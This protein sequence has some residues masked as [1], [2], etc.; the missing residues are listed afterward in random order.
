MYDPKYRITTMLLNTSI[1]FDANLMV[2]SFS[3][4]VF[5]NTQYNQYTTN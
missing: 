2:N 4:T 3:L 1:A 5:F